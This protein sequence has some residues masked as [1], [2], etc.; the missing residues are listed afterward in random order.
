MNIDRPVMARHAEVLDDALGLAQ[1]VCADAMGA[2]RI[3]GH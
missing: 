2:V 1:G 3:V